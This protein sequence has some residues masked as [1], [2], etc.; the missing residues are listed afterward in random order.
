MLLWRFSFAGNHNTYMS[1]CKMPDFFFCPIVRKCG[2]SRQI[3]AVGSIKCYRNPYRENR[4]DTYVETERSRCG[5][6]GAHS[7]FRL[8]VKLRRCRQDLSGSRQGQKAG[9]SEDGIE[10]SESFL[11]I[12]EPVHVWKRATMYEIPLNEE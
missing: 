5:R 6:D 9:C 3:F 11:V 2:F 10:A 4:C 12:Q 7:T 1:S 8:Q